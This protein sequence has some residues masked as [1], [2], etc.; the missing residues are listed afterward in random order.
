MRRPDW[1]TV[2]RRSSTVAPIVSNASTWV[3]SARA[4]SSLTSRRATQSTQNGSSGAGGSEM[5]GSSGSARAASAWARVTNPCVAICPRTMSRR[6]SALS[7]L[8][9]GLLRS[10]LRMMPAR[11]A[12]SPRVRS[13]TSFEKYRSAAVPMP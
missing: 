3:P 9:I 11:V 1:N 12:A 6:R 2:A 4:A 5:A 7:W 10:G 8:A 13:P